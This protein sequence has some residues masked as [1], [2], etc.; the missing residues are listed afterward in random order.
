M[1]TPRIFYSALSALTML[2]ASAAAH[3]DDD[4]MFT[5]TLL[6]ETLHAGKKELS[7]SITQRSQRSQGSYR[8]TQSKTEF[9]YGVTDAWTLTIAARA[10]RVSAQD[11]NSKNSRNNYTALGDGDEVSGG[12]PITGGPYV[13][14]AD[15]LP[16]PSSRYQKAGF[17]SIAVESKF[18]FLSADK[19]A[20]GLVGYVEAAWGPKTRG[21]EF[22][23]LAHQEFLDKKWVLAGNI[24]LEL[25]QEK[26]KGIAA[27]RETKIELSGGASYRLTP[28]WRLGLEMR[29][30][31]LWERGYT[32]SAGKRDS[33]T[34]FAGPTLAFSTERFF[35]TAGYS[36]Q[37]PWAT[38]YSVAAGNEQIGGRNFKNNERHTVRVLA[39]LNF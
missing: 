31:H 4:V 9:E 12:G 5:H 6:A 38:A 30:V 26:W 1:M 18:Q 35:V 2:C 3:A 37:L 13:K 36:Q 25:E 24:G 17:E 34:W 32:L 29:N 7:Q 28:G 23:L 39:G 20:L 21:L 16:L 8:L 14:F 15:L 19:D 27:E 33:S 11:N 10:Y 22:K